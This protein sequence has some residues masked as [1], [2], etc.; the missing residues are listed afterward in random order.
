M[1]ITPWRATCIQM[2]SQPV[3][4][5]NSVP[6]AEAI[7]RS[8]LA[9]GVELLERV[10]RTEAPDTRLVLF[11]EFVFQGPPRD[12]SVDEWL[13]I[14][15]RT[16][17]GL[18][19]E[20]LQEK[21]RQYQVYVGANQFEFDP[22]W[23][24]RFFNCC[25]LIDP[26]GEIILRYRRIYT[27]QWPSP[28]DFMDQYLERY[29]LEG[30]FPVVETE[31]GRLAMYPCGEVLVPEAARMFMLRGSE[32]LLHPDN[33]PHSPA[34]QAA[35][36]TRALE[37]MLYFVSCNVAGP[38]GFS[39]G[40]RPVGGGSVIYDYEGRCLAY[41]GTADESVVVSAMV[42][43]EAQ[44]AARSD[45]SM[46]NRL[47]RTRFEIYQPV[48]QDAVFYPANQFATSPMAHWTD[49]EPVV[50]DALDNLRTRGI[51]STAAVAVGS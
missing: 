13:Q 49:T 16:L 34:A 47:A 7:I 29:G 15:A 14:G 50:A 36:G 12:E 1:S 3:Y 35:K 5:S 23:A 48:Y 28:H 10:M 9:R 42:D 25:F 11:P 8:N 19:S 37:N 45:G 51:A 43:V 6:K 24:G 41:E 17:P 26:R 27:A 33:A 39:D 21:A 44:R 20:P 40:Q 46:R 32:V 2:R 31:L 22:E 18:I 38:I 4:N 30:T